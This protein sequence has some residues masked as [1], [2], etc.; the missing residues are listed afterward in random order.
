MAATHTSPSTASTARSSEVDW[1]QGSQVSTPHESPKVIGDTIDSAVHGLP[2]QKPPMKLRVPQQL[3]LNNTQSTQNS[4]SSWATYSPGTSSLVEWA[5]DKQTRD[6]YSSMHQGSLSKLRI[7]QRLRPNHTKTTQDALSSSAKPLKQSSSLVQ[8]AQ[9][10]QT[11]GFH[12]AMRER[13]F[14]LGVPQRLRGNNTTEH[15]SN[16]PSLVQWA[17]DKQTRDFHDAM[18]AQMSLLKLFKRN[19]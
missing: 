10:Q 13:S 17:H 12:H 18:R 16:S 14:K 11:R 6:F 15:P 9:D 5:H 7:P 8:R 2:Y 4:L 3:R 1:T 19:S